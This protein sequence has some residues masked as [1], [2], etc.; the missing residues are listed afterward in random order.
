MR[1]PRKVD[2]EE[3]DRRDYR[4]SRGGSAAFP[5]YSEQEV[6][7]DRTPPPQPDPGNVQY[8]STSPGQ[9]VGEKWEEK[10]SPSSQQRPI[11]V[12]CLVKTEC[13][14]PSAGSPTTSVRECVRRRNS[15]TFASVREC[16]VP[17]QSMRS[18]KNHRRNIG[19]D[20]G[21]NYRIIFILILIS[22]K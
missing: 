1:A 16:L 15:T 5:L 4:R 12:K 11:V 2:L 6:V 8:D 18:P 20:A 13:S 14:S 9:P 7:R 3:E 10:L 21:R 19:F 22:V 17:C